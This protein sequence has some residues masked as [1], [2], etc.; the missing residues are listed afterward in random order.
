MTAPLPRLA[1]RHQVFTTIIIITTKLQ[2]IAIK[3]QGAYKSNTC[4][5]GGSRFALS[6]SKLRCEFQPDCYIEF[7]GLLGA[8]AVAG[9]MVSQ[10]QQ[11]SASLVQIQLQS[12]ITTRQWWRQMKLH[13]LGPL[14]SWLGVRPAQCSKGSSQLHTSKKIKMTQGQLDDPV[15]FHG[16]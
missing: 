3:F 11:N 5:G 10:M 16:C 9:G 12:S 7:T 15:N 8:T 14:A 13:D 4:Q 2:T 1:R 6:V